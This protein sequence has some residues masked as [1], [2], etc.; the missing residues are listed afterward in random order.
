MDSRDDG[1]DRAPA[2]LLLVVSCDPSDAAAAIA[3]S[4]CA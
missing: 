2:H 4:R 3:T 1:R